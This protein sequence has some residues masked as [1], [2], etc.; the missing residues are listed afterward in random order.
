MDGE[1]PTPPLPLTLAVGETWT[2]TSGQGRPVT[3][4]AECNAYPA[5]VSVFYTVS[6]GRDGGIRRYTP[7]WDRARELLARFLS[8]VTNPAAL[9]P[10]IPPPPMPDP[11][12][13]V[14]ARLGG[15]G[16]GSGDSRPEE[17]RRGAR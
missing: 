5:G 6:Y 15:R 9:R 1:T 14:A 12:R 10:A 16:T 4:T 11:R 8:D 13:T 7:S 17:A 2:G 3:V